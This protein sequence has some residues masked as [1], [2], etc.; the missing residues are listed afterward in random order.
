MSVM[1]PTGRFAPSP[2]G[3]LHIGSL[4]TALASYCHIKAM[5]G[6]WLVRLEDT[7]FERCRPEYSAQIERDLTNLGLYFDEPIVYQSKRLD[8]YHDAIATLPRLIYPCDCSRKQLDAH[9]ASIHPAHTGE[10]IYP[11]FCTPKAG[12]SR[13]IQQNDKLRLQLPDISYVFYDELLGNQWQNPQKILG[14][15]VIKRSNQ[16][17]NY[18]WAAAI[19]DGLQHITHILRGQ[20]ILPMTM[21]QTHIQ[22]LLKLPAVQSFAHLPLVMNADGQKL[23]KQ[24]LAK[25]IDTSTADKRRNLLLLT[26]RLLGQT[27]DEELDTKDILPYA[28][29]HWQNKPL[30]RTRSL[31]VIA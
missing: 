1:R 18:I 29:I 30:Q 9:F 3:N 31:G 7:D 15:V 2:T 25:P 8:I 17:I 11:K 21:A 6:R 20:D 28:V 16:V 19:D 5:G 4:C 22:S 13:L 24:N 26:L 12:H 27:I 23:S 14:D 10:L